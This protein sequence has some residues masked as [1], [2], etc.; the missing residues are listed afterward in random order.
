MKQHP[1]LVVVLG[2]INARIAS[3]YTAKEQAKMNG[4]F[5]ACEQLATRIN[6]LEIVG[7]YVDRIVVLECDGG[8]MRRL[9]NGRRLI[10]SHTQAHPHHRPPVGTV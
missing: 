10:L 6:T 1:E 3:L 4:D 7:R 9:K 2:E 8:E 5:A